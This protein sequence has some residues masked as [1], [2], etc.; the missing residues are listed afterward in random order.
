M[1]PYELDGGGRAFSPGKA[2]GPCACCDDHLVLSHTHPGGNPGATLKSISHRC[3]LFEVVF[4]W[5]LTEETRHLLLGCL[6]GGKVFSK[7]FYRI[8]LPHTSVNI[9]H[10]ITDVKSRLTDLCGN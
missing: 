9:S 6:Q 2:R 1:F 4:V 5:E 10:T 7:S 8:E 3:H